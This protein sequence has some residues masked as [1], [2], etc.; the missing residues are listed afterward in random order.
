[1]NIHFLIRARRNFCHATVR[2]STQRHNMRE[3][4]RAI[5]VVRETTGGWQLERTT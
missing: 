3:W 1:M 2:R 5:R 4:I